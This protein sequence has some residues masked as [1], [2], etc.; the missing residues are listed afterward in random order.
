MRAEVQKLR[1]VLRLGLLENEKRDEVVGK[2][3]TD[4]MASYS[5]RMA[6]SA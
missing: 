1:E 5:V 2:D 3:S 4:V 6:V